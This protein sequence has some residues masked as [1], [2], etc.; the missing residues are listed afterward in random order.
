MVIKYFYSQMP[1]FFFEL[2]L[3]C[4]IAICKAIQIH[5]DSCLPVSLQSFAI[6]LMLYFKGI[7]VKEN[8]GKYVKV[9]IKVNTEF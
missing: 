9:N 1:S 4:S 3:H 8:I 5:I 7:L 6:L 2:I